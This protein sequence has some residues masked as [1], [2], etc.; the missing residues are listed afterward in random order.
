MFFALLLFLVP[1]GAFWN[2]MASRL[3]PISGGD[4]SSRPA[5]GGGFLAE[6]I[7][8]YIYIYI[9]MYLCIYVC[10]YIYIYT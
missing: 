10:I 1:F 7:H 3:G 9:Y 5:A 8:I 4:S 2:A 6:Q